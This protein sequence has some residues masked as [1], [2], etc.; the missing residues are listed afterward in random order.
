MGH[1]LLRIALKTSYEKDHAC[2]KWLLLGHHWSLA[3]MTLSWLHKPST[4]PTPS[5]HAP[6]SR[7]APLILPPTQVL[8]KFL[9]RIK[10]ETNK[11]AKGSK[12]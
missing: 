12:K 1:G 5:Q 11:A 7:E 3:S 6:K 10:N 2:P 8:A 9:L 4:K